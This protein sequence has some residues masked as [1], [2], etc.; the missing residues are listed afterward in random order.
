M[1]FPHKR[2]HTTLKGGHM[3]LVRVNLDTAA[4]EDYDPKLDRLVRARP[5]PADKRFLTPNGNRITR[6]EFAVLRGQ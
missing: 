3:A 5:E 1:R 2:E 6:R 4:D